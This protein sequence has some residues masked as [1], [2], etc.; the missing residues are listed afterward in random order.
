VIGLGRSRSTEE[1]CIPDKPRGRRDGTIEPAGSVEPF[2][3]PITSLHV[4]RVMGIAA[5]HPSCGLFSSRLGELDRRNRP[6]SVVAS[7]RDSQAMELVKPD[8]FHG[9][10]LSVS[11]DHRLADKLGL[12]LLELGENRGCAE[13]RNRHNDQ[14]SGDG[15]AD[16]CIRKTYKS[17]PTR[18]EH[19]SCGTP[20][21]RDAPESRKAGNPPYA[22]KKILNGA[23]PGELPFEQPTKFN[24]FVNLKTA[25]TLGIEI[26]P[27]LLATADEVID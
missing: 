20:P 2:A 26:P 15:N 21:I 22:L 7:D 12:S 8:A 6:F 1:A 25:K 23:A 9:S 19:V 11:E 18:G 3:K 10:S 5:L 16:L 27:T 4:Y 14:M 17:W 13:L 24:L